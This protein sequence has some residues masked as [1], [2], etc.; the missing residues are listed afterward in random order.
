MRLS[1]FCWTLSASGSHRAPEPPA[2]GCRPRQPTTV[3]SRSQRRQSHFGVVAAYGRER[4]E[5]SERSE[6]R[7]GPTG[8][9]LWPVDGVEC[10][11]PQCRLAAGKLGVPNA[12]DSVAVWLCGVW[13]CGVSAVCCVVVVSGCVVSGR[14]TDLRLM[15]A[16]LSG[17]CHCRLIRLILAVWLCAPIVESRGQRRLISGQC[18]AVSSGSFLWCL[19]VWCLAVN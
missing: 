17:C 4:S 6:L 14:S 15:S 13:L 11:T 5:L 12:V 8:L 10:E 1:F 18:L 19:V 3:E 7:Q 9:A 16:Q 2:P